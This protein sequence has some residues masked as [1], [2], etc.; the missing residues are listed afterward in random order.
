VW[1]VIR[2]PLLFVH[3]DCEVL[4]QGGA[5]RVRLGRRGVHSQN[6]RFHNTPNMAAAR[7]HVRQTDT[8]VEYHFGAAR[9]PS[10]ALGLS[11]FL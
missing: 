4:V 7:I 6:R 11:V 1:T 2:V 10:F 9:N 3:E 5:M 8:G